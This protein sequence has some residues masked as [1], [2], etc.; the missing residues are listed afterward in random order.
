MGQARSAHERADV[1]WP[2]AKDG[3]QEP[4]SS[5]G[6]VSED[7]CDDAPVIVMGSAAGRIALGGPHDDHSLSGETR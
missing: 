7:A 1:H 3:G 2:G 4:W 6:D 5:D